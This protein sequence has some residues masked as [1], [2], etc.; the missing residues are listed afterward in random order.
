MHRTH[1]ARSNDHETLAWLD[2]SLRWAKDRPRLTHLLGLVR[3]EVVFE[4]ELAEEADAL[5]RLKRADTG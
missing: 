2:F 3:A 5:E 4:I 1:T